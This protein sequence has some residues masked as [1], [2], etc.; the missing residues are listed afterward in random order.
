MPLGMP[1]TPAGSSIGSVEGIGAALFGTFLL[2]FEVTSL[3][4]LA[5]IIGAVVLA[6]RR[7]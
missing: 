2:P 5:G 3:L 6:R 7:S 1:E 4:L